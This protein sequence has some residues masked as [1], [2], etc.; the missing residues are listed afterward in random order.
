MKSDKIFGRDRQARLFKII[1]GG[2]EPSSNLIRA[3]RMCDHQRIVPVRFVHNHANL[4]FMRFIS[5][6][7][8]LTKS[9]SS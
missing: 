5:S 3:M 6:L 9:S 2:F 4:M 7:S 1:D 8:P